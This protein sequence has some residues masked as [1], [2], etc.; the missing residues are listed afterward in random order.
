MKF[1]LV[2]FIYASTLIP[3]TVRPQEQSGGLWT[4]FRGPN[5]CGVY[6]TTG[7]PA[8]MSPDSNVIWKKE[9]PVGYSSPV[10][11]GKLL[12]LT[13]IDEGKLLTICIDQ[14]TGSVI[15][16]REAPRPRQERFDSRNNPA[17]PSPVLDDR[18]VYV[19]FP[20][21]GLLA[22]DFNGKELWQYPLGPFCN[23]YG[24]G[25]SPVVAGGNVVLVCDQA[26]GSFIIAV[27]RSTGKLAWRQ[28]RPEATSG[29][30]TPV[31]Y[32][33]D[34]GELQVL[35]AGSFRLTAYSAVRGDIIWWVGG[36]SFEMKSTPVMHNGLL[37]INGFATPLNDPGNQMKVPAFMDA[38]NQFDVNKNSL[39]EEAELPKTAPYDWF[40]FVDLKKDGKLDR[41]DWEYFEAAL[42]SENSMMAIRLGGKGDCTATN[43][44]WK[45]YRHVPQLPS[46]LVYRD[47]LYMIS[48]NGF[49]TIFNPIDGKVLAEGKPV[50][51]GSSFYA[52]PVASD[53]K[54]WFISRTGRITVLNPNGTLGIASQTDLKQECYATPAIGSQRMFVRTRNELL[55]F[56]VR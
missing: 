33:P 40:S 24:M 49:A 50:N 44:I 11:N 32:Q 48:D 41:Q 23:D 12:F 17:S 31:L 42:A 7:L 26:S 8:V 30:C 35:V 52:S 38:L 9:I 2:L 29:H 46:P 14:Q 51:A 16:Q 47:K 36:L 1:R 28:E 15:W 10:I 55:C 5:G 54:I 43:T 6:E 21:F 20:D 22:Y 39:L 34:G 53:G 45:Y 13:A 19:F 4:Q 3:V 37:F 18:N 27:N 56:G 25:A